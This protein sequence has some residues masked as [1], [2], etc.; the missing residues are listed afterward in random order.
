MLFNVI[1]FD[2]V[3]R[4]MKRE[5]AEASKKEKKRAQQY[6]DG[7]RAD[8]GTNIYAALR[9]AFDDDALDT[10]Y[11]MSDGDPSVGKIIDPFALRTEVERWNSTRGI[12]IHCIAVGQPHPLLKGLSEDHNGTYVVVN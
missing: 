5:M 3:A 7:L 8:G 9:T 1:S 11:L 6:V 4:P 2:A 10:I 12:V